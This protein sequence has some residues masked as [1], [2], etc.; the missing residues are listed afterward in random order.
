MEYSIYAFAMMWMLHR[1][2]V[3][4]RELPSATLSW[5]RLFVDARTVHNHLEQVPHAD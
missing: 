2:T 3:I 4:R 5:A 1:S